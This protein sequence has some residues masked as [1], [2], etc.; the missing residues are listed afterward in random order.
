MNCFGFGFSMNSASTAASCDGSCAA[1]TTFVNSITAGIAAAM[2]VL[3][4]LA[5]LSILSLRLRVISMIAVLIIMLILVC[6]LSV[7]S[8]SP[9]RKR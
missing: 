1:R 7:R 4:I 6:V 5:L 3:F 2:S 8:F 9:R